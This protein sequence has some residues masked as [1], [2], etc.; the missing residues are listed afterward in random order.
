MDTNVMERVA[1]LAPISL[2]DPSSLLILL[3]V[4]LA[5]AFIAGLLIVLLTQKNKHDVE[6]LPVFGAE[7]DTPSVVMHP[8]AKTT[9][10]PIDASAPA[11]A[12]TTTNVSVPAT[13]TV[14]PEPM[15]E[16]A[17][18]TPDPLAPNPEDLNL[19]HEDIASQ[20]IPHLGHPDDEGVPVPKYDTHAE[21]LVVD[22]SVAPVDVNA[23]VPPVPVPEEN[24]SDVS[25]NDSDGSTDTT[26]SSVFVWQ[27]HEETTQT[28]EEEDMDT[29]TNEAE[30][31]PQ[32]PQ[33][34]TT[35]AAG[36]EDTGAQT[37]SAEAAPSNPFDSFKAK[38]EEVKD[39]TT[40][41][42]EGEGEDAPLERIKR[43]ALDAK[44]KAEEKAVE[45]KDKAYE[46]ATS[47]RAQEIRSSLE[48]KAEE[49]KEKATELWEKAKE[50]A[51]DE[52]S[53]LGQ[54]KRAATDVKEKAEDYFSTKT[55]PRDDMDENAD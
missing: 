1:S 33:D 38:F 16:P 7:P 8:A 14:M 34:F 21:S 9:P 28:K 4:F 6:R 41:F 43:L 39:K 11:D 55:N 37:S 22:T 47:E 18:V 30:N 17:P 50:S 51:Q 35:E 44:D 15:P 13:E 26:E 52:D 2:D 40:A 23:D 46:V 49:A 5:L 53:F 48:A 45:L 3:L 20:P 12:L 24:G 42:F 10:A 27:P 31:Q 32:Y 54:A 36:A 29:P 25:E 19:S